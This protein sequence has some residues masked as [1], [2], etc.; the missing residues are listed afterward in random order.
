MAKI[1]LGNWEIEDDQTND[2]LEFYSKNQSSKIMHIDSA[3]N[4]DYQGN[5]IQNVGVVNTESTVS[6]GISFGSSHEK[7]I[8][9]GAISVSGSEGVIT[10]NAE[11]G[12]NDDLDTIN[13]NQNFQILVIQRGDSVIT[14]RDG[15]GNIF[16]D[17]SSNKTLDNSG[18]KLYLL[19]TGNNW[20]EISFTNIG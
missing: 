10:L 15:Q 14:V 4:V 2:H 20:V 8:S 3:G 17:G 6:S 11:A 12:S 18:D 5:D 16:L 9:S 1:N 13:G 7:T 19:A